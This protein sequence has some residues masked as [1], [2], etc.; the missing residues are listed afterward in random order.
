[1]KTGLPP[2]VKAAG[3]TYFLSDL[4]PVRSRG[5]H[6]VHLRL[7]EERLRDLL[8]HHH[9]PGL[10]QLLETVGP[11]GLQPQSADHRES[12]AL[13]ADASRPSAPSPTTPRW[14]ACGTPPGRSR[15]PS[16]ARPASNWPTTTW[17][18]PARNGP[19]P[20]ASTASSSGPWTSS[21]GSR[22]W[23]TRRRSSRWSRPPSSTPASGPMDFTAPVQHGHPAPGRQ[24]VHPAGG[25]RAVGQG[26]E[27]P[28]RARHGEQCS[29]HRVA[30]CVQ[31]A[32][33]AV[34]LV[35]GRA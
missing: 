2:A 16:P 7:Q 18:R 12:P 35:A 26:S 1:M 8:W 6:Q 27:V 17:P 33:D 34:L 4:Y 31:S 22:T 28:L 13:P 11:A 19:R 25:R 10:H 5:L 14:R 30:D 21:S 9:H 20:S 24:R 32:A 3:Y 29:Q 23:T 15:T